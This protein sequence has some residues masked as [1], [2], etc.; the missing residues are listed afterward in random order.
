[1]RVCQP[2]PLARKAVI[3]S[4]ENRMVYE[5]LGSVDIGRPTL[6]FANCSRKSVSEW[7]ESESFQSAAPV[8]GASLS[9]TATSGAPASALAICAAVNGL[10]AFEVVASFMFGDH[11]NYC[12]GLNS[13]QRHEN[14]AII[15]SKLNGPVHSNTINTAVFTPTASGVLFRPEF[16]GF[17]RGGSVR[18]AGRMAVFMFETPLPPNAH[19]NAVSG[20]SVS[21]RS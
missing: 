8:G 1:M 18:K 14:Y 9:G 2:L 20:F 16:T 12:N 7:L 4:D 19:S 3:T 21:H 5:R 13:S 15:R 10:E 11:E 6:R 17:G